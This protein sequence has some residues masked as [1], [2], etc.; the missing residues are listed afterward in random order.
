MEL[1]VDEEHVVDAPVVLA[2]KLGVE[3]AEAVVFNPFQSIL[4]VFVDLRPRQFLLTTLS[5][6]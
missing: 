6:L 3:L 5:S 1:R 2:R 4:D